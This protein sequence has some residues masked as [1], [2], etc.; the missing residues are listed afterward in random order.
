MNGRRYVLPMSLVLGVLLSHGS[1][2]RAAD[3]PEGWTDKAEFSF[4]GTEGNAKSTSLGF[5]NTLARS[6]GDSGVTFRAGGIRVETTTFTR[7]ASGGVVTET[8]TKATTAESYFLNGRYDRKIGG[9][10]FWFAGAGWDRNEPAG[11]ENRYVVEGGVGNVWYDTDDVKFKT[12]YGLTYTEQEDVSGLDDNF[13]GARF[14]WDYSNKF[15]ANTTYTN[16]LVLDENLDETSDW[17]ADMS[18]GLAVA[19]SERLALKAGLQLLYDNQPAV[20]LVPDALAPATP[21]PFELD[22]LDTILTI[23]L[24]VDFK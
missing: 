22:E 14:A 10:W 4:V 23:S 18:N 13:A 1:A 17:R 20:E 15:G 3:A 6:W 5:K 19:M 9:R 2:A 12:S 11:I 16:V 7:T 8:E 21:V 24:V